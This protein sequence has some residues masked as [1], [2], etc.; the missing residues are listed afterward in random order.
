MAIDLREI[1]ET[2][3]LAEEMHDDWLDE[4]GKEV[5]ELYEDDLDSRGEWDEQN[6][7][8][9]KLA[10]QVIEEKS[11]PWPGA[12][13]VKYPLLSTAAL[14]FHARSYPALVKDGDIVKVK[15]L[16][17]DPD[18]MKQSRAN[19]VSKYMSYQL[20]EEMEDW[21]EE[22]D[23]MLYILPIV[24]LCY[25]KT[26]F[27]PFKNRNVSDLVLPK[28]LVVDYYAEDFER[29]RKTHRMWVDQNEMKEY[30]NSGIY[31]ECELADPLF[32][33]HNGSVDD[34]HGISPSTRDENKPFE[35]LE[36]HYWLDLDMD[37]YREPY[38]VT[39]DHDSQKVLRI[40]PRFYPESVEWGID[41][42][43]IK[44]TPIE[45]FTAY[46]FL[47]NPE[48]PI[49]SLGFGSLLG[50][51]NSVINTLI[52][53]LTDNG[54]LN[55]LGG[56]FLGKGVKIRGGAIRFMPGEW[57]QVQSTGDD[58]RKGIFPMPIQ[59]PSNVL[60]QLLGLMIES[61]ERLAAVKDIMVGESPGQ[62]QPYAT[63]AAVLEQGLKIFVSIHKR[64]FRSLTQEYRKLY[65]LNRVYLDPVMYFNVLDTGEDAEVL[66]ADFDNTDLNILP[67]ADPTVISEAQKALKADS[68]LQKM[69]MGLPLNPVLVTRLA[70]EA[71]GHENID[72]LMQAPPPQPDFETQ[73][74]MEEFAHRQQMEMAQHELNVANTQYEAMK[75]FAQAVAHLAKAAATESSIE[76]DDIKALVD[77]LVAQE[78]ALTQRLATIGQLKQQEQQNKEEKEKPPQ[79]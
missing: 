74:K 3:N 8:W 73:L 24:G 62:N 13:N 31:R 30:Q 56:G 46:K 5:V 43:V 34:V 23:R 58:L 59:Q 70:L 10:S 15:K 36:C 20:L 42:K 76:R 66:R 22:M 38:I 64:I 39:V 28:D 65:D 17:E 14:Q 1:T 72:E 2:T 52:N 78:S 69:A 26:Y 32:K 63:T 12:S 29:A 53:Q 4:I 68:L 18:G 19:R 50:P 49:Y 16:G 51:T 35:I 60:F 47:P 25:K 33:E 9:M 45:Y 40:V 61:G 44:I 71:E 77:S 6:D 55:N 7:E 37:G 41:D 27:S 75:D 21:Q 54:T 57:K 48:S 79:Q 11:T 67:S